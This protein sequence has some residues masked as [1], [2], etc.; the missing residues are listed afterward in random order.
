MR[1]IYLLLFVLTALKLVV[2][3]LFPRYLSSE[4]HLLPVIMTH[5]QP[6][7]TNMGMY[8]TCI[9]GAPYMQH[10]QDIPESGFNINM[11]YRG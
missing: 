10:V 11:Q 9:C 3:G 1:S 8:M 2:E 7:T 5:L 6:S 4:H